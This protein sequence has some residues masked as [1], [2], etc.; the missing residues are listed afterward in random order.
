VEVEPF[1]C[2]A[3]VGVLSDPLA[4]VRSRMSKEWAATSFWTRPA[5]S[6]RSELVTMG[7]FEGDE[8]G[9]D[10]CVERCSP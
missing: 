2:H 7:V 3:S 1:R 10:V 4:M 9:S 8:V 5:A 6:S